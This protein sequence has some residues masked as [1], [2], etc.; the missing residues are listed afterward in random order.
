MEYIAAGAINISLLTELR[1]EKAVSGSEN[2]ALTNPT[3]FLIPCL[4][5]L[6]HSPYNNA[7]HNRSEQKN[8]STKRQ[9]LHQ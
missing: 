6:P 1:S 2:S 5:I 7:N 9:P 8:S 3:V 4:P